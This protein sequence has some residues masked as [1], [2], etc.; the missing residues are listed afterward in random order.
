MELAQLLYA[1]DDVSG[2]EWDHRSWQD[3]S[4]IRDQVFWLAVEACLRL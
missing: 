4:T 3:R 2:I 1:G